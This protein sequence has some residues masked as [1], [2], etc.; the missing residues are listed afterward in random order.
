M[1][2]RLLLLFLL[3]GITHSHYGQEF[4]DIK[5]DSIHCQDGK[6][7]LLN[8]SDEEIYKCD[9][10]SHELGRDEYSYAIDCSYSSPGGAKEMKENELD[11]HKYSSLKDFLNWAEKKRFYRQYKK[12]NDDRFDLF[13]SINKRY[14]AIAS[15]IIHP[16]ENW[17]SI[18]ADVYEM[19]PMRLKGGYYV[20]AFIETEDYDIEFLLLPTKDGKGKL[21]DN[22]SK[23]LPTE[24]AVDLNSY[25]QRNIFETYKIRTV[26]ES[27]V[28]T[29]SLSRTPIID[30]KFDAIKKTFPYIIASKDNQISIYNAL[31][32]KLEIE[33]ITAAYSNFETLQIIANNKIQ[34]LNKD[35]TLTDSMP[36]IKPGFLCGNSPSTQKQLQ[37]VNGQFKVTISESSGYSIGHFEDQHT[38]MIEL[39]MELDEVKYLDNSLDITFYYYC[40]LK[41]YCHDTNLYY[42]KNKNGEEG[43]FRRINEK[44]EVINKISKDKSR[45]GKEDWNKLKKMRDSIPV[46]YR[47]EIIFKGKFEEFKLNGYHSPIVFKQ[48]ELYGIFPQMT[49]PKYKSIGQFIGSLAEVTFQNDETGWVDLDGKEIRKQ[50]FSN[51]R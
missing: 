8:L 6:C 28:L 12:R 26:D 46:T 40:Y 29:N 34:W 17:K 43:I 51:S 7:Y 31:L 19:I 2:T 30:E 24:R 25:Y 10:E 41:Y 45:W 21:V 48:N 36:E 23:F 3:F 27:K 33:N 42:F 14:F 22:Q 50:T 44:D 11:L 20:G 5:V 15:G 32:E 16:Q 35:F 39:N 18:A 1:K 49:K 37:K 38:H 13:Q 4:I 9:I 47:E